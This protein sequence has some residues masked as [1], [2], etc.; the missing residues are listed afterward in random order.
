MGLC[1]HPVAQ[2]TMQTVFRVVLDRSRTMVGP[3]RCVYSVRFAT[4]KHRARHAPLGHYH[5]PMQLRVRGASCRMPFCI[6]LVQLHMLRARVHSLPMDFT[7]TVPHGLSVNLEQF[8]RAYS[9][10]VLHVLQ[11]R[12]T[13]PRIRFAKHARHPWSE[14]RGDRA[15][16]VHRPLCPMRPCRGA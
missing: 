10:R 9:P 4:H 3:V 13:M 2:H 5:P 6:L 1:V 12:L 8:G 16:H 15:M 11:E 7:C 14:I